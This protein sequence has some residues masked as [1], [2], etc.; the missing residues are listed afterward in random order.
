MD[1][2]FISERKITLQKDLF[3]YMKSNFQYFQY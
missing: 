1:F 3:L 2:L